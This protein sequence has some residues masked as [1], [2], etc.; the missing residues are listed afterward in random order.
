MSLAAVCCKRF[1]TLLSAIVIL[2][3]AQTC[4]VQRGIALSGRETPGAASDTK[5]SWQFRIVVAVIAHRDAMRGNL[6][7]KI[8]NRKW[9]DGSGPSRPIE[10]CCALSVPGSAGRGVGAAAL[11][12]E[13]LDFFFRRVE[14]SPNLSAEEQWHIGRAQ[15][16]SRGLGKPGFP[17]PPPAGG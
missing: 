16:S 9:Y 13:T 14:A 10:G 2:R 6:Q 3:G 8:C 15:P 12:R 4:Q 7:S 1:I 5:S 11:Q 17:T